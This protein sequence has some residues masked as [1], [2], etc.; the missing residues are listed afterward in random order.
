[1]EQDPVVRKNLQRVFEKQ[2]RDAQPQP[3]SPIGKRRDELV[4]RIET[5]TL[6]REA[7]KQEVLRQQRLLMEINAQLARLG[8]TP[9]R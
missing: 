7:L 4:Q 6:Q 2:R 9:T 3:W 5:L 1:M 8:L